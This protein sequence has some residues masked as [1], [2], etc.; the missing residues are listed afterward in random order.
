M[1]NTS[2][3]N[4]YPT[5]ESLK[6]CKTTCKHSLQAVVSIILGFSK[7]VSADIIHG[8][9]PLL[10]T[11]LIRI[12]FVVTKDT[13]TRL[14]TVKMFILIQWTSF[15]GTSGGPI[16]CIWTPDCPLELSCYGIPST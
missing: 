7:E 2:D 1:V 16:H 4:A 14:L 10:S 11:W 13:I 15:K 5:N 12:R 9:L 3:L 6:A 8:S